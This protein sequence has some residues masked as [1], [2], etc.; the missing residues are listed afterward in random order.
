MTFGVR[1][2]NCLPKNLLSS[3]WKLFDRPYL[4]AQDP[5]I[6]NTEYSDSHV[7][8]KDFQFF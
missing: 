3:S 2:L 4:K 1:L 5:E 8:S 6:E 7:Q